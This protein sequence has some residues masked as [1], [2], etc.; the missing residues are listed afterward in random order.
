MPDDENL[1]LVVDEC[2]ELSIQAMG[3]MGIQSSLGCQKI[4]SSLWRRLYWNFCTSSQSLFCSCSSLNIHLPLLEYIYGW[5]SE[6]F[7]SK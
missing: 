5:M 1:F 3:D 4:F 6:F 2:V 7:L